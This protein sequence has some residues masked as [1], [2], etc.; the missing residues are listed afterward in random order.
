MDQRLARGDLGGKDQH[1]AAGIH[2][3]RQSVDAVAE[4]GN[5]GG[6]QHRLGP[7]PETQ[8]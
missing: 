7:L 1:A 3:L 4:V 8:A 5:L 2:G 6:G